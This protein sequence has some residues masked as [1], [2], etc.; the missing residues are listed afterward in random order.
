MATKSLFPFVAYTLLCCSIVSAWLTGGALTLASFQPDAPRIG[1]LPSP[2]WLAAWTLV[3]LMARA[4]TRSKPDRVTLLA[5]PIVLWAPWIPLTIPP[6]FYIWT[7]PLR[8]WLWIAVAVA[9]VAP[10][11]VRRAP[12]RIS[13]IAQDPRRAPW[14]AAALAAIAYAITAYQI[15]PQIP[16]G[17][18]PH[19]LV[20]AQ[21]VLRDHDLKI[22]NN[23]R[24]GDYREYYAGEL[25]PDYLRRGTNGEIYSIH[26]PGLA[27]AVAPAFALLGYPGV[28]GCL[29]LLSAWATALAWKAA[30]RVTSDV[31]ASW[32][33]WAAVAL[34]TPFFF[35]TFVVYPDALGGALVMVGIL[36]LIGG[37]PSPGRLAATGAALATLPW[38]HTRY[39]IAAVVLGATILA[40]ELTARNVAARR[41]RR[42]LALAWVP[43]VSAACWFGF[44]YVIYGTPDPRVPYAGE[45]QSSVANLSR[46]VVGLLFDQQFGLLPAAPVFLCALAGL[47]TMIRRSPR[48]AAELLILVA[49]YGLLVGA[50]Q[51]WWGGNSS[52]ARFLVP[53][54]L[55][56]AIPAAMWF[57]SHRGSTARL[58]GLGALTISLLITFT[59]ASVGRGLLLYNSRDGASR[60]LT[61]L[62]PLVNITT[63]LP[64]VF[65]TEPSA[66]WL[67]GAVWIAAIALTALV[68]LFMER[69][70][71]TPPAV[72]VALG[73]SAIVT[74]TVALSIVWRDHAGTAG[75]LVAPLTPAT[76]TV[77]FLQR[78]DPDSGQIAVRYGPL[79]RARLRD[80]LKD[81]TLA[82]AMPDARPPT[83]PLVALFHLPAGAYAI[84]ATAAGASAGPLT[85]TLDTD[86]GPA[87]SW[88]PG[89]STGVWRREIRLPI[90]VPALVVKA[91]GSRHLVVRPVSIVGSNHRLRN[92]EPLQVVRYGPA[93]VFLM[94]GRAY[95]ERQGTWVAGGSSAD[96]V[97]S[98]DDGVRVRLFVRNPPVENQITLESD[99]W[100]EQLVF[101][102]GEERTL[103][104]PVSTDTGAAW[105]RVSAAHGARPTQFEPG[106]TDTR[107]LGCW[108]ETRP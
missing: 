31:A 9:I 70:G 50:Y 88:N 57:H 106:S 22:E 26:A 32:F 59:L 39:A 47:A 63:G 13:R 66:V 1:I 68:G 81:L 91:S 12:P 92:E 44:F 93:L 77:A 107:F 49:P 97:V 56:L 55:P 10:P 71:A 23:H 101:K 87:W 94:G 53:V 76:G 14:L 64:S 2:I 82:D 16:T 36:A 48:L 24:R 33:G 84:E 104:L 41:G 58:L 17:D 73:F 3:A 43:V 27:V 5:L 62:S 100:R 8:T 102:P 19:Y 51:M 15:S 75:T 34:T 45:T 18:E 11:I 28:V 35:Q 65:Q 95:V 42:I 54:L 79:R 4:A 69:R 90:P 80:V 108:I 61:W 86:R 25:K 98:P 78:Y 67:H 38:L 20:I 83:D 99:T 103:T 89:D 7:G 60:L 74:A 37:Q 30:W 40:R 85:V 21:S 52:P 29:T 96:F 6:A 105:I 72:A 46:G